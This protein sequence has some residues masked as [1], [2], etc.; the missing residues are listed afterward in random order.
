MT[1]S[2]AIRISA[3]TVET[4]GVVAVATG[5]PAWSNAWSV[6]GPPSM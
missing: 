3:P 2:S 4:G 5:R 6:D 1:S